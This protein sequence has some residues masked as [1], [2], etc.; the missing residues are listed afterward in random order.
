MDRPREGATKERRYGTSVPRILYIGGSEANGLEKRQTLRDLG[1]SLESFDLQP[2]LETGSRIFRSIAHRFNVGA[3][4]S[5]LNRDLLQ[6][7]EDLDQIDLVWVDKGK[8]I[9]PDTL[10]AIR[11]RFGATIV[12]FANDAMLL[13][14]RSRAFIRS[15]PLYDFHFTTKRFE[16]DSYQR[17]G[18]RHVRLMPNA[19]DGGRFRPASP[20]E[21]SPF[22]CDV[23]FIGRCEPHYVRCIRAVAR[24]G[25]DIRVWGPRWPRYARI[26]RWARGIVAGNGVWGDDYPRAIS[27]ARIAIGLL[28]KRFPETV[29]TRSIEIPACGTLLLAE[30]TPEH[31]KLFRE[32]EEAAFF[33]SDR[34]L[35]QKIEYYLEHPDERERLAAAGRLRFLESGYANIERFRKM[36]EEVAE[37]TGR[38]HFCPSGRILRVDLAVD[39]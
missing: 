21:S 3:P 2:Y 34:E 10:A 31:Q 15:I 27:G 4:V 16:V 38:L 24:S 39:A 25:V 17:A 28:S 5:R 7:V 9:R 22:K 12:H 37:E 11:S 36:L 33:D 26:H 29:T 19:I 30:R 23:V 32:G 18:A 20:E 6:F 35:V 14:N 8:W 1:A 13:H